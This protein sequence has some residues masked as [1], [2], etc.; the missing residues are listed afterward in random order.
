M[1]MYDQTWGSQIMSHVRSNLVSSVKQLNV[2]SLK[3]GSIQYDHIG[4]R[5][6]TTLSSLQGSGVTSR[7]KQT[8]KGMHL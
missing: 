7:F 4:K 1:S 6:L 8:A 2:G 3:R 5:D